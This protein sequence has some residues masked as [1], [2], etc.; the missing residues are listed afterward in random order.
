MSNQKIVALAALTALTATML[1]PP[2]HAAG[3]SGMVVVRDPQTGALRAPTAAESNALLGNSAQQRKGPSQQVE[4]VGPGGSRKVQLGKSALV[5]SV[6]TKNRDGT[7]SEQC[8]SGEHAAH[9]A[10][11][12][13]TPAKESHHESE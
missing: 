3:Q 8:V 11:A 6:V 1:A 13:P 9:A 7:L 2:A 12:H 5:Y 4:T 10:I